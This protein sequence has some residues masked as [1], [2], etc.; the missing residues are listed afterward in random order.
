M[1]DDT[2][3][4][5]ALPLARWAL[6]PLVTATVTD[7]DA[8]TPP[9]DIRYAEVECR[10]VEERPVGVASEWEARY[11]P[12]SEGPGKVERW[13]DQTNRPC[14]LGLRERRGRGRPAARS[15]VCSSTGGSMSLG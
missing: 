2:P 12:L 15:T 6:S 14:A 7:P 13:S 5:G 11:W 9:D 1:T 8:G 4:L 10:V 3:P